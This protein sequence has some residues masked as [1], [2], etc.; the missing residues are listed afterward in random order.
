[1]RRAF[2]I[3]LASAIA[4]ACGG[5]DVALGPGDGGI[6]SGGT[7]V[8]A[9][10]ASGPVQ[11]FG[12]IIVNGTRYET[13]TARFELRDTQQLKLGMTVQVTGTVSADLSTGVASLVT[14]TA[15]S[16]GT[17]SGIDMS[18]RSFNLGGVRVTADDS[19]VFAPAGGMDGLAEGVPVQVWGLPQESGLLATRIERLTAANPEQLLTDTIT[20]LDTARRTFRLGTVQV[21]YEPAA[22]QGNWPGSGFGAGQ[23]ARVRGLL[24]AS[25]SLVATGI[26]PAEPAAPAAPALVSLGG[27]VKQLQGQR[28]R[29]DGY[30]VDSSTAQVTGGALREGARV[31][32]V[33]PVRNGVLAASQVRVREDRAVRPP[34]SS[35]SVE[36]PTAASSFSATGPIGAFRSDASFS[37][38]GQDIDASGTLTQFVNGTRRDLQS[39][40]KVQV[41]GSRVVGDVLFADVVVFD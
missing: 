12:S 9:V 30:T 29:L 11:G 2:L 27:S 35:P 41:I 38:R 15:Q 3:M 22:V 10:V 37:V 34:P 17:V 18:A 7:G 5:S 13:D 24:D 4:A 40:R 1:M 32:V 31:D 33:G 20:E 8:V 36:A 28:F 23:Q 39:G 21:R 26:E 25:G 14:S 16:R 19:T 6:G